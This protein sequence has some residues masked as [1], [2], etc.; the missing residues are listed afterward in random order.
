ME[1]KIIFKG[2]LFFWAKLEVKLYYS[3]TFFAEKYINSKL[4]SQLTRKIFFLNIFYSIFNETPSLM[5]RK[6]EQTV[7]AYCLHGRL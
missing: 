1:I 5:E 4:R 3:V 6:K 7:T 2:H